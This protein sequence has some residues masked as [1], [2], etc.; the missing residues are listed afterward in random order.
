MKFISDLHHQPEMKGENEERK[1]LEYD[2]KN[3]CQSQDPPETPQKVLLLE[4]DT[5]FLIYMFLMLG[6]SLASKIPCHI[7]SPL[8]IL[9]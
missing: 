4:T 8:F 7:L 2:E 6:T 3:S 1:L 9:S 5:V